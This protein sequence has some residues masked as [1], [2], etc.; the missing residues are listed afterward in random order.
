MS[1]YDSVAPALS[2]AAWEPAFPARR[3]AQAIELRGVQ[4]SHRIAGPEARPPL[5][6]EPAEG[7]DA[8]CAGF[9]RSPIPLEGANASIVGL[10]A[11]K[12]A[13]ARA[14]SATWARTAFAFARSLVSSSVA[15]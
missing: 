10:S 15:R 12:S 13:V 14:W 8:A 9:R 6:P 11:L 2:M 1:S 5:R 3:S 7:R 4:R